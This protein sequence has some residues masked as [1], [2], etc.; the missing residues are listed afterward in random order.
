MKRRITSLILVLA[1]ILSTFIPVMAREE[2]NYIAEAE[3]LKLLGVFS[4]TDIGFELDK[5][6]TRLQGLAMLIRLIGKEEQ[7]RTFENGSSPFSD[8]PEWGEI[9][10]NYA[11][12]NGLTKGIN[13]S[14]FGSD[15]KMTAKAYVTFILRALGYDDI[16]GDFSYDNAIDFAE[17]KS[18]IS[19][20]DK[21]ELNEK[22]FLRDHLV[23]LSF[24]S[25]N[26]NIKNKSQTLLEK[27]VANGVVSKSVASQIKKI[28]IKNMEVHFIDVGQADSIL[29][30]KGNESM[31]IDAGNNWDGDK[32][33]KYLKEQNIT[34]LKYLI[35]THPHADHIGG[36]DTIIDN[37]EIEK[38]ILPNVTTNTKTFEDVLDSI[39]KKGLSITPA[40]AGSVYDLNGSEIRTLAPNAKEY[41]NLNNY[42]VVVKVTNGS[43]AFLFTGDAE[44]I[45]ER[46]MIGKYSNLLKSDVLKLGHHGS[47]TSTTQEFLDIVN[48]KYAVITV[49]KGNR[50]GHPDEEI[51]NRLKIKG[52]N[53]FRTDVDGNIIAVSDGDSISFKKE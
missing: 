6:A 20:K 38:I 17:A 53:L 46:E 37:F 33:V 49:G 42:S 39:I 50:Y 4:G 9:Y 11:Y 22:P 12:K 15:D 2:G 41:G 44:E 40:K 3:K 16:K 28:D 51:L 36:M 18:I 24:I 26:S 29:I 14:L 19:S 52:I 7:A 47:N 45:S 34:K 1:I 10:V 43:N 25:L 8:V 48:P 21:K 13:N 23:K 31:L 32:I 35:G 5:E 30:K 27:L